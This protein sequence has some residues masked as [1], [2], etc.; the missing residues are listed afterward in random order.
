MQEVTGSIPVSSTGKALFLAAAMKWATPKA[1]TP[2]R[3]LGGV[4]RSSGRGGK[5][6]PEPCGKVLR[7][8]SPVFD[9]PCVGAA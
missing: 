9:V 1:E 2:R 6:R 7:L 4:S 8:T 5:T 3:V